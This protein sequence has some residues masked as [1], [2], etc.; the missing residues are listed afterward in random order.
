[1]HLDY[2]AEHDRRYYSVPYALLGKTLDLRASDV[3]L[4]AYYRGQ[5]VAAHLRGIHKGQ[6][7][8]DATHRPQ[9]HRHAIELNHERLLR[10]ARAIGEATA[11]VIRAQADRRTHRDQTPRTS[12]GILR[13]A[14]DHGEAQL[15]AACVRAVALQSRLAS[16]DCR[17]NARRCH[18]GSARA[19]RPPRR[20]PKASP[21]ERKRLLLARA[22][23][24]EDRGIIQRTDIKSESTTDM[25]RNRVPTSP[26]YAQRYTFTGQWH[27][28][29]PIIALTA[30]AFT[31][32]VRNCIEAGMNDH[33]SKPVRR[34]TLA[35][36]LERVR[37][38]ARAEIS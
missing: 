7:T 31:D 34:Q 23:L 32:D 17:S 37:D 13:L 30:N 19:Q 11:Q 29:T 28:A 2:H 1:M 36:A 9:K 33:I 8:T 3:A 26:E 18:L 14:K 4:E 35:A 10:Q 25:N 38:E 12:M 5:R 22:W 16:R 15:E 24:D 27:S 6:F 20:T 21:R